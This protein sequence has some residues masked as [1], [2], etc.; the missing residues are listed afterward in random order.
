MAA[1]GAVAAAAVILVMPTYV[2]K[3]H[4]FEKAVLVGEAMAV[5][6]L[7]MAISFVVADLG[8]PARL[9]HLIP[10]LGVFNWPASMLAWWLILA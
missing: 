8:G 6:A 5:S 4:D 3:D 2:L 7:I 9:W 10:G 1:R